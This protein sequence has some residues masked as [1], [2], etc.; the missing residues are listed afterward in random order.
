MSVS[1]YDTALLDKLKYWTEDT[2][3]HIYSTD[4]TKRLF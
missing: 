3:I 2:D 1:L 4:E